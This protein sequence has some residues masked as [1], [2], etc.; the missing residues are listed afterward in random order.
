M[1]SY[2]AWP[3]QHGMFVHSQHCAR[4]FSL[5]NAASICSHSFRWPRAS[6][7]VTPRSPTPT[8]A[9]EIAPPRYLP[10]VCPPRAFSPNISNAGS[11][12][13]RGLTATTSIKMVQTPTRH[14]DAQTRLQFY[15]E[16]GSM[17]T[18]KVERPNDRWPHRDENPPRTAM[19]D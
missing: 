1:W 19:P 2:H 18:R 16:F 10:N 7:F 13:N 9:W 8:T 6:T 17:R 14:P 11:Q 5:S 3:D 4:P 15:D 12:I